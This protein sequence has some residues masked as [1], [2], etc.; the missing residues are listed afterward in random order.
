MKA[1][2]TSYIQCTVFG[3]IV[4]IVTSYLVQCQFCSF[5]QSTTII[6]KRIT[7]LPD[8]TWESRSIMLVRSSVGA[9][10]WIYNIRK[11]I[12]IALQTCVGCG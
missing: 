6:E 7:T 8:A 10:T 4:K 2:W 12:W 11:K 5:R 1:L 9:V 3:I